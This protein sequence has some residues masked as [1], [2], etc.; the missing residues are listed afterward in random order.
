M[1]RRGS[2]RCQCRG[3]RGR[4]DCTGCRRCRA[5]PPCGTIAPRRRN[6]AY[7]RCLRHRGP[8]DCAWPW[9]CLYRR[10]PDR[11]GAPGSRSFF[12]ALALFVAGRHSGTGPARG[13]GLRRCFE[14]ARGFRHVGRHAAP[15]GDSARRLRTRRR[16]RRRPRRLRR[17]IAADLLGSPAAAPEPFGKANGACAV[18][19][20]GRAGGR[21]IEPVMPPGRFAPALRIDGE[22]SPFGIGFSGVGVTRP[23]IAEH[24]GRRREVRRPPAAGRRRLCAARLEVV[25]AAIFVAGDLVRRRPTAPFSCGA[26]PKSM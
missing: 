4:P 10:P 18:A 13:P 11:A 1:P 16:H 17:R 22:P 6:P 7:H 19:A 12:D 14:P 3:H 24:R 5:R 21:V 26:P 20:L 15:L 2:V 8:R 25:S 23:S 9:R